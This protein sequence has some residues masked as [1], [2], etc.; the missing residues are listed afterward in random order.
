M[1]TKTITPIVNID[2][3]NLKDD[4]A[5]LLTTNGFTLVDYERL[6]KQQQYRKMYSQREDVVAKR[7]VYTKMRYE[8]MKQLRGLLSQM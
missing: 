2:K 3:V 4:I 7:R 6:Q 1:T 5:D 8:R